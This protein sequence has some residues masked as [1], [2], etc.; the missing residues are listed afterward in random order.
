MEIETI[1]WIKI[2][3]NALKIKPNARTFEYIYRTIS[4]VNWDKNDKYLYSPAPKEW[5][6][7]KWFSQIVSN[8]YSEYDVILEINND[9]IFQ[10]IDRKLEKNIKEELIK[11]KQFY[12]LNKLN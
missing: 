8:V 7:V 10:N 5:D 6:Y 11:I 3:N 1:L 2:E 12:K 4:G 9:T